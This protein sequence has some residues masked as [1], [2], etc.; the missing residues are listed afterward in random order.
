MRRVIEPVLAGSE[1]AGEVSGEDL[2]YVVDLGLVRIDGGIEMANP[3][4]REMVPRE[5]T[6][7][8]DEFIAVWADWHVRADGSPDL[9]RLLAAFQQYFREH[10]E[11]W[12][13][14]FS[15]KA[16]APQL[17]LQAYLQRVVNRGGRLEREYGLGRGRT[18]LLMLWP[19]G[20]GES[21]DGRRRHV[22]ELKVAREGTRARE[23]GPG[24]P[25]ADRGRTWTDAGRN[26]G[27]WWCSTRGRDAV[28]KSACTAA[29]R[30]LETR[31]SRSGGR[32]PS[33]GGRGHVL[34]QQWPG[35]RIRAAAERCPDCP[36]SLIPGTTNPIGSL[37]AQIEAPL[38]RR[39]GMVIDCPGVERRTFLGAAG[40]AA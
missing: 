22:I 21:P 19:D 28:G 38:S 3:I 6:L 7:V 36:V 2:D 18:D 39:P 35:P 5:L 33:C 23:A 37:A 25:G 20:E 26:R 32:E 9:P 15:Y 34:A 12:P 40:E 31:P 4:Y 17:L 14:G 24:G 13:E 1:G 16:V 27:T 10:G 11:H 8:Q 30:E 29:T